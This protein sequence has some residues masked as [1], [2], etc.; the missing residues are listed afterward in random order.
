MTYTIP[1]AKLH[2]PG[3]LHNARSDPPTLFNRHRDVVI[4]EP[5]EEA[6]RRADYFRDLDAKEARE[7]DISAEQ[8][9]ARQGLRKRD[10][11]EQPTTQRA[12][13]KSSHHPKYRPTGTAIPPLE[14]GTWA[15]LAM[16]KR[17]ME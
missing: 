13:K 3:V 2:L 4:Q 10:Y 6:Q 15:Q 9:S 12:L 7:A 17:R 5:I 11:P 8:N 14:T 16:A 1:L